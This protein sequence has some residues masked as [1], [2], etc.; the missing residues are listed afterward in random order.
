MH[1]GLHPREYI[2]VRACCVFGRAVVKHPNS[3]DVEWC[4]VSF[5]CPCVA[6]AV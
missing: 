5:D 2:D 4:G 1:L 3:G 6:N